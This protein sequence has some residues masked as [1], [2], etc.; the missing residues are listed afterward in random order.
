MSQNKNKKENEKEDI[1]RGPELRQDLVSGDW[2]I[3]APKRHQRHK[4]TRLCPFCRLEETGQEKPVLEY[5]KADGSWSLKVIPNKFPSLEDYSKLEKR[6]VGPFSIMNA[7]GFHEVIITHD[8]D[9]HLPDLTVEEI[10]EV[11]DAYQER[12][13][14]LMNKRFIDYISIF[15]NYGKDGGASIEHPHSQL[16]A[17]TVIDPDIHRSL[18]GSKE[19]YDKHKKCPHCTMIE[20]EE[21]EEERIVYKNDDFIALV[22]FVCRV[23]SEIRI[24]PRDHKAYFERITD[25]E[26]FNLAEVLKEALMRLDIAFNDVAYNF[27]IHTAP[28]DGKLY[29]HYH[30]HI[31]IF[32]KIIISAGFEKGA[33]MEIIPILPEDAAEKLREAKKND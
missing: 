31:E 32:P 28:C 12:Y 33:R 10:A 2:V 22:P 3:F 24:Y 7:V 17:L 14:D 23:P 25:E 8:H 29:D 27:F 6:S 20:W 21:K 9:R 30:W 26:K 19:F 16:M 18:R 13:L 1:E 4:K 11:I 15:H 5:T